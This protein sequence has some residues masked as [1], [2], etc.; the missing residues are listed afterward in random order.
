M[1][2]AYLYCPPAH[3]DTPWAKPRTTSILPP[4]R[5]SVRVRALLQLLPMRLQAAVSLTPPAPRSRDCPHPCSSYCLA[6]R[7]TELG[8]SRAPSG[9]GMGLRWGGGRMG[10]MLPLQDQVLLALPLFHQQDRI[11]LL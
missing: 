1:H 3:Q 7:A 2:L 4:S 10:N 6:A 8:A 11:E 5:L 9:M